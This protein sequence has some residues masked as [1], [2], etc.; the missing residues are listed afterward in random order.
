[1]NGSESTDN[2]PLARK[3]EKCRDAKKWKHNVI[4]SLKAQGKQYTNWSSTM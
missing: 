4:E 1:M 2:E 3:G